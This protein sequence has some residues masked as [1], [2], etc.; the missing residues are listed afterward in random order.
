MAKDKHEIT[1]VVFTEDGAGD[2]RTLDMSSPTEYKDSKGALWTRPMLTMLDIGE[3]VIAFA[4]VD[5]VTIQRLTEFASELE[6][7]AMHQILATEGNAMRLVQWIVMAANG[8][9]LLIMFISVLSM[10]GEMVSRFADIDAQLKQLL[11]LTAG[12]TRIK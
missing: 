8:F 2:V 1:L 7:V 6:S 11:S 10:N 3:R 12:A 4:Y 9:F 5:R